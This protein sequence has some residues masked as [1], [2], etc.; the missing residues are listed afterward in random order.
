MSLFRY[1]GPKP[2]TT[3]EARI[4]HGRGEDIDQLSK[5]VQQQRLMVLFGRSGL[6][7]SS[8]LNAGLIPRLS[9]IKESNQGSFHALSIR[10]QAWTED[11]TDTPTSITRSN[12]ELPPGTSYLEKL[13]PGTQDDSLWRHFKTFQEL[14]PTQTEF[15]LLFDQFEEL[16]SFPNDQILGFRDQLS[17]LLYS[18][19]PQIYRSALQEKPDVLTADELA[20]LYEPLD[21]RGLF[22]IRSDRL[23]QLDSIS[24]RLGAILKYRYELKSLSRVQAED[25]IL[26]PAYSDDL[27][28]E[29]PRFDYTDEALDKILNHLSQNGQTLIGSFEL[30][31]ICQYVERGLLPSKKGVGP[32]SIEAG[33]LGDLS[34]VFQNYYHSQIK[35]LGSDREQAA[36]RVLIEDHLIYSQKGINRRLSMITEQILNQGVS[37]ELLQKLVNSYLLRSEPN[38]RGEGFTYELAHDVLMGPIL[39]LKRERKEEENQ[40]RLLKEK[41]EAQEHAEKQIALNKA[42]ARRRYLVLAAGVILLAIVLGSFA[43]QQASN[44]KRQADLARL[45]DSTASAA[46]LARNQADS[47]NEAAQVAQLNAIIEKNRADSLYQEALRFLKEA[48]IAKYNALVQKD[49]ALSSRQRAIVA[50]SIAFNARDDVRRQLLELQ[51]ANLSIV[52]SKVIEAERFIDQLLFPEALNVLREAKELN[53]E[54]GGIRKGAAELLF[55]NTNLGNV[56]DVLESYRLYKGEELKVPTGT[57]D[58]LSFLENMLAAT[59]TAGEMREIRTKYIPDLVAIEGAEFEL[60]ADT[61]ALQ[62]NLISWEADE[63][64]VGKLTVENYFIAESEVTIHQFLMHAGMDQLPLSQQQEKAIDGNNPVVNISWF[65]AIRYCNW[66]SEREGL[67]PVYFLDNDEVTI[68]MDKNGYRLPTEA[69]WEYAAS[70]G[71]QSP[72][73]SGSTSDDAVAWTINN[74]GGSPV[75]VKQKKSNAFGLFDMSGNVLEWCQD[76][77]GSYNANRIT[78]GIGPINGNYKVFRGGAFDEEPNQSRVSFRLYSAP[79]DSRDNLGFRV[80]RTR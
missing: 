71:G 36:A 3:A 21:V 77:Y 28:F 1:P 5:L 17:E 72:V 43:F 66:L 59:I 33:D 23:H 54:E 76:W 26:D 42:K 51:E 60:G 37:V 79:Q 12:L 22:A 18:E 27:I 52:R 64:P 58:T 47:S 63:A 31:V 65:D 32:F 78:G 62:K 46:I 25:A 80:A 74:S 16:F 56:L 69:E 7:K 38:P 45:A 13:V 48:D 61:I 11:R 40:Q 29:T 19:I 35:M 9:E 24:D 50:E 41:I 8:L 70:E 57:L 49:S 34:K 44:A 14:V 75:N 53:V 2:F 10:F 73:F 55:V 67:A 4:F 68:Q 6:G 20:L 15:V 30:Q 39:D